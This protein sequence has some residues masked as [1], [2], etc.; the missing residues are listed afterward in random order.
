MRMDY[1]KLFDLTGRK[2]LVLGAASGIGKASAEALGV[3]RRRGALRRHRS[4]A[5]GGDGRGDPRRR[6]PGRRLARRCR[7]RRRMSRRWSRARKAALGRIDIAVTTPG[8]NIR[9]PVFDY[10]EAEFDRIVDLNFKGTFFFFRE[11]GRVMVE[12]KAGSIIASSSVRATTIEPGLA[13]Y[14]ATKAAISLLVKGFAAEVGSHGVRVNAIAPSIIETPLIAP[15]KARP[16]I[17]ETY[18]RH[19]VI[20]PLGPASRGRERGRLPRLR[21]RELHQRQHA[22]DRCRLDRDRRAAD[23]AHQAQSGT[24]EEPTAPR[25]SPRLQRGVARRVTSL[26]VT[27]CQE[28]LDQLGFVP[29]Y[30]HW[31]L[32]Q[33]MTLWIAQP[34]LREM[35]GEVFLSLVEIAARRRRPALECGMHGGPVI[36]V[37]RRALMRAARDAV[38]LEEVRAPGAGILHELGREEASDAEPRGELR[39]NGAQ[40]GAA[41]VAIDRRR[42]QGLRVGDQPFARIANEHCSLEGDGRIETRRPF[43]VGLHEKTIWRAALEIL[44]DRPLEIGEGAQ[45]FPAVAADHNPAARRRVIALHDDGITVARGE[46]LGFAQLADDR[47]GGRR[48]AERPRRRGQQQLVDHGP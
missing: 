42:P 6:R 4:R 23:R 11:V 22:A 36:R 24:L 31:V 37:E 25:I 34:L 10:S 14:G 45:Q 29:G 32:A 17:Y 46:C 48:N 8:I 19:T 38:D 28:C 2:A 9:K 35:H 33:P 7:E 16:E 20:Q 15:I 12:Q 41:I 18:A 40:L 44:G 39:R 27:H 5:G 1:R 3:A 47:E 13:V 43:D 30:I 26:L 21:R